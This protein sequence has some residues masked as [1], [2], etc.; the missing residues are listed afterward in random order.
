MR[1]YL[2]ARAGI[3]YIC[4]TD[5]GVPRRIST[6]E[7]DRARADLALARHV[8]S[9]AEKVEQTMLRDVV[10][11][12]YLR[13]ARNLPSKD[14]VR[15][16]L[17]AVEKYLPGMRVDELTPDTQVRFRDALTEAGM[18][19]S[20]IRRRVGVIRAALA[21]A[22]KRGEIARLPPITTPTEQT[23]AGARAA[24]LDE[25]RALLEAATHDHQRRYLLL[26]L[27]T[28]GRPQAILELTWDRID[29][30]SG[31]ADLHVPGTRR[32][33]KAR[34]VVPLAAVARSYLEARRGLGPVCQWHDRPLGSAK[35]MVR[36]LAK[37][38]GI[39]GVTP[40]SLRKAG[41]TWMRREGVP[42]AD[43]RGMLGHSLGGVT[44]V[45]AR[46][47]PAYMRAAADS[48]DRLLRAVAPSWLASA[49]PVSG[50]RAWDRTRDPYHVKDEAQ[51]I[52]QPLKAAN[53]D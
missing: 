2:K 35:T 1:F 15:Y 32:T 14:Q 30:Q 9:C 12:Y 51:P 21:W 17:C 31:T 50:G 44:D 23:G 39:E 19:P 25:L 43:V 45:Y 29:Q 11:R 27:A 6:G 48:L 53:D 4:W 7:R 24:T 52:I 5:R 41:A 42:V 40:Y 3:W 28:C 10:S 8:L 18:G 20:T 22:H 49:L 38:A 36:K 47:D 37:E 16:A 34:P 26:A 46:F 33:K 13:H